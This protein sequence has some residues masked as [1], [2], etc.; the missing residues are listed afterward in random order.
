MIKANR[1]YLGL[2]VFLVFVTALPIPATANLRG[3][4]GSYLEVPMTV[5][6]D[7]ARTI[8][9]FLHFKSNA[10]ENRQMRMKIGQ[11][12][13]ERFYYEELVAENARLV[14]L[15]R[16]KTAVPPQIKRAIPLRVIGKSP[17]GGNAVFLVDKGADAELR[18]DMLV[19]ADGSVIG[20][21]VEIGPSMSKVL[22]LTD[23]DLRLG[24]L[25]QRTRQ[26]GLMHG[27]TIGECRMKY[28]SLEMQLKKGDAV[29][30]AGFGGYFPKGL[31]VG[32]LERFWKEPGQMY[33]VAVIKP[34][35]DLSRVEEVVAIE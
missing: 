26:E 20:K 32:T 8:D 27:T 33:Q 16:L 34:Y 17:L 6:R 23:P 12:R 13:A 10:N 21:I 29:E 9:D 28:I 22:L 14:K 18:I 2:V 7:L 25:L 5:T 24:G 4:L 1:A 15:L 35:A 3:M 11:I 19:L 30:T 31:R